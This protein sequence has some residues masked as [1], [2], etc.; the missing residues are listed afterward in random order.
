MLVLFSYVTKNYLLNGCGE[1][2]SLKQQH[3]QLWQHISSVFVLSVS[4]PTTVQHVH[5]KYIKSSTDIHSINIYYSIIILL[6]GLY[7]T[8]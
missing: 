6:L 4:F 3:I 2:R 7:S 1:E 8:Y 5:W